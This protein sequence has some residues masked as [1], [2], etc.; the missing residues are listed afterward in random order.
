MRRTVVVT[1]WNYQ[2]KTFKVKTK[3]GEKMMEAI[4]RGCL[5]EIKL[6]EIQ[7]HNHVAVIP[8]I[9]ADGSGPDYLTMKEAMDGQFL[10]VTELT[11]VGQVPE[12]KVIN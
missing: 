2:G 9:S 4:V 7:I 8:V 10:T 6:G 5:E 11:E 1:P 3:K 12:L